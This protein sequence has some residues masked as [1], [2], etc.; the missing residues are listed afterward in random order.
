M[1]T[2]TIVHI[3]YAGWPDTSE[4]QSCNLLANQSSQ[5][6]IKFQEIKSPV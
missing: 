4:K 5:A 2:V 3:F 1:N 6:I